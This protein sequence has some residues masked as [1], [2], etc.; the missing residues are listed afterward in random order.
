M[1]TQDEIRAKDIIPHKTSFASGDG[2]YGDGNSSFFMEANDLLRLTAKNAVEVNAAPVFSDT[3]N[4]AVGQ[5]VVYDG[6]LKIFKTA[7]PAGAWD[8]SQVLDVP[9]AALDDSGI[10]KDY[11]ETFTYSYSTAGQGFTFNI[12]LPACGMYEVEVETTSFVS[13]NFSFKDYNGNNHNTSSF[14]GTS[15]KTVIYAE[16]ACIGIGV[17]KSASGSSGTFTLKLK[18]KNV[19]SRI[20]EAVSEVYTKKSVKVVESN[21][22]NVATKVVEFNYDFKKGHFYKIVLSCT[23]PQYPTY[24]AYSVKNN[25]GKNI[26]TSARYFRY[27]YEPLELLFFAEDNLVSVGS[28]LRFSSSSDNSG[29]VRFEVFNL[30]LCS[31]EAI[32]YQSVRPIILDT[33]FAWD[34]DDAFAIRI[35]SWGIASGKIDLACA[36][37][38][39]VNE[40]SVSALDG[41][42]CEEG[43]GPCRIG[44]STY[45]GSL[46]TFHTL[47]SDFPNHKLTSNSQASSSLEVYRDALQKMPVGQKCDIVVTGTLVNISELIDYQGSADTLSGVELLQSRVRRIW[48]MGGDLRSETTEANF[49]EYPSAT[50]NVLENCPVPLYV[51]GADFTTWDFSTEARSWIEEGDGLNAVLGNN[52]YLYRALESWKTESGMSVSVAYDPM[53]LLTAIEDNEYLTGITYKR[54]HINFD[55]NTRTQT[56]TESADGNHY[57]MYRSF[58]SDIDYYEVKLRNIL[59]KRPFLAEKPRVFRI[60]T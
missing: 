8:A 50:Y 7:H 36:V 1:A 49:R 19:Y 57:I 22:E 33:D 3:V 11:D 37:L 47:F 55:V 21:F 30:P 45:S 31:E 18:S 9:T 53:L 15:Y 10:I 51:Q 35:L 16:V 14:N 39:K 5:Y 60:G 12:Y 28:W 29:T 25:A 56:F 54:G 6:K 2:F 17:W 26:Y 20:G 42:L 13:A 44:K 40:K 43:V 23:S 27:G 48:I 41:A 32:R 34:V 46:R 4:Y 59:E 58:P 24:F 52:D 38:S